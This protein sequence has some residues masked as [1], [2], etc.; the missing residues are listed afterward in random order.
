VLATVTVRAALPEDADAVAR[1]LYLSSAPYYDRV[2]GRRR[3][4]A[5]LAALY[6]R[7]G[8]TVSRETCR[9]AETADGEIVGAVVAFA[10]SQARG[11]AWRFAT[12]AFVHRSPW[13]WPQ[14]ARLL[15]AA[16]RLTPRPPAGAWYVDALAV[17]PH[18]RR[19]GVA[20]ALLA[21]QEELA[22]AAGASV[23]ALETE[24]ENAAARGLYERAAFVAGERRTASRC[25]AKLLGTRGM[26]A[27]NKPLGD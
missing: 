4:L 18:A 23:I 12:L 9:V 25:A 6:T 27:Y 3:V 19:Q 15:W 16:A 20:S 14:M 17:A 22:R 8:H 21:A 26:V 24:I 11:R 7:P 2:L 5:R 13:R 1:L 10:Q